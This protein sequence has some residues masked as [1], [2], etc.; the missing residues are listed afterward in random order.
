MLF[1]TVYGPE[2]EAIYRFIV[3]EDGPC[4]RQAIRTAFTPKYTEI[5][6]VS[7][8]N[9]DDALSFLESALLI[10]ASE[11]DYKALDPIPNT[12]FRVKLLFQLRNL[13]LGLI[14]SIH[15]LDPLYMLI[16]T[17]LFIHPDLLFITDIHREANQLRQVADAGGLSR[18]KLQ[19]WKR[20]MEFL[21]VGQ[22]VLSGFRCAYSPSLFI[23]ILN[24]WPKG[25]GTL[26]LFFEEFF[27]CIL[28]F[29]RKNGDLAQATQVSLAYLNDQGLIT[30]TPLQDSPTKPY[31]GE[32]KLRYIARKG[33]TNGS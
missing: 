31:F 29:Q 1:R 2:L 14:K 6:T 22:R 19:A 3:R 15:P 10:E 11:G 21:G 13:E 23:E 12:S 26:Q 25:K 17:E 4:S 28:P 8:Q 16:L 20:V 32:R 5:K 30:L 24:Q 7:Y 9:V 27:D 33:T 18:E